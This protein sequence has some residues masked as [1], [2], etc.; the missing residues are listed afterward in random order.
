M[1][2]FQAGI[3]DIIA[4]I[5][6]LAVSQGAALARREGEPEVVKQARAYIRINGPFSKGRRAGLLIRDLVEYIDSLT[7]GERDV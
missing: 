2:E 5:D 3:N 6:R 7:A 4:A 1:N